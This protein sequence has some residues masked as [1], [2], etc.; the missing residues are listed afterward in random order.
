MA[1]SVGSGN[2]VDELVD[3]LGQRMKS[4]FDPRYKDLPSGTPQGPYMHGP[5]G[6]FATPGV[7]RDVISTRTTAKGLAGRLPARGTV[8]MHPLYAYITGYGAP[9]GTNPD[10]VCDDPMT[11]GALRNCYQTADFGRYSF[12]TREAEVNRLGQLNN[13]GELT[14]FRLVNPTLGTTVNG[15]T[16]PTSSRGAFNMNNE[17]RMRMEELGI[18]FED[19]LVRQVYT[20][21]PANNSSNGGYLEFPGL[22]ILIGETKVDAKTGT[23]CP[24]LRS[25][26]KP[27]NYANISTGGGQ[28][29][30]HV[31]TYIMRMLRYKADRGN[32]GGVQWAVTMRNTL[33]ME[34]TAVW[35]CAYM[36]YR[37]E[38][39]SNS[40]TSLVIDANDQLR[41]RD[42]MRQ[43]MY[44]MVDGYRLPVII[45]DGIVEENASDNGAI[46]TTCF[47]SDL[48]I[49]PLTI[50]GG[51]MA[52]T[53]WEYLDY[54]ADNGAMQSLREGGWAD[55]FFWTDD[56]KY[57]W[58]RKPPTNWCV[59]HVAKIE[60]RLILLTPH[61][62]GRVTNI[63][64]CP[65]QHE[66]DPIRGDHYFEDAGV[67]SRAS[68]RL[69]SDWNPTT[70]S[71]AVGIRGY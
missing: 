24:T 36:T 50:R 48:Y 54:Q 58:H 39:Q 33:F 12:Q 35:P 30:V 22:D 71:A 26:I 7:E 69:Y 31:M 1:V 16:S 47:A 51:M 45:D 62:A 67:E 43:G 28:D 66:P 57:L 34:L 40:Q 70:P 13:R 68:D 25:D 3:L 29:I 42:E 53:Y 20:G 23:P 64:Y 5:G 41:M 38:E 65:L 11:A 6:L 19:K 27:F 63:Q 32:F 46:S 44:L 18:A 60:P 8:Y 59:Q 56:G 49:V 4:R 15:I 55:N 21:N 37:C 61:L 14:D 10:G 2:L 17:M 9:T 52:S